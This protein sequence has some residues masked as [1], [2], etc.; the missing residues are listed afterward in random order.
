MNIIFQWKNRLTKR[1]FYEL[2]SIAKFVPKWQVIPGFYKFERR[3]QLISIGFVYVKVWI[4]MAVILIYSEDYLV[5]TS[6]WY[7]VVNAWILNN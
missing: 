5:T 7:P 2:N 3:L 6:A 4:I 1:S